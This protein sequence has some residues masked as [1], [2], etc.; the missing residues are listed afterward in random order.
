MDK[1][2]LIMSLRDVLGTID[3]LKDIATIRIDFESIGDCQK[4]KIIAHLKGEEKS[5]VLANKEIK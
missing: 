3:Q 5:V 4:C 1:D 2:N